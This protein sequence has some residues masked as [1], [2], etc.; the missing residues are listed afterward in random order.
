[1][2]SWSDAL[3]KAE[4]CW[5]QEINFLQLLSGLRLPNDVTTL[6]QDV[7]GEKNKT[8]TVKKEWQQKKKLKSWWNVLILGLEIRLVNQPS[9]QRPLSYFDSFEF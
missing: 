4:T 3:I 6:G 8:N 9:F 7:A 5:P 2:N 1:M